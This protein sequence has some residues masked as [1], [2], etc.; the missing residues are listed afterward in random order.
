MRDCAPAPPSFDLARVL[1][2]A[3]APAVAFA[4]V[5]TRGDAQCGPPEVDAVA[6]YGPRD[7]PLGAFLH[8]FCFSGDAAGGEDDDAEGADAGA[9]DPAAAAAA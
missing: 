2:E 7:R 4:F 1:R 3:S 8:E 5:E 9:A 6:G